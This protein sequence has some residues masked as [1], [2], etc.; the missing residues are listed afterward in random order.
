M[1]SFRLALEALWAHKRRSWLSSLGMAVGVASI[2]VLVSLAKGVQRDVVRQVEEL[3]VNLIILL[4][5]RLSPQNPFNP[6]SFIGLSTLQE[7]DVEV[8]RELPGV[9]RAAPIMFVAGGANRGSRWADAALILG[10]TP[11]WFQMRP[12]ALKTGRLLDE[13]DSEARVCVLGPLPAEQIFGNQ[14]PLGQYVT[15][16]RH[17]FQVVGVTAE[18][19]QQSL[20]G[21]GGF[22]YAI[23]VPV[24]AMQKATGSKQIHRVIVQT[25][26]DVDPES[27]VSRIKSAVRANHAGS[28]D[29]SVITQQDLLKR[30]FDLLNVLAVALTGITS[31][32]LFVG[33]IGVMNVM[34]MSVNE[35]VREI[36]IR[37]TVG[38]RRGDIFSQFLMEALLIALTG[39]FIGIALAVAVCV[40]L[41]ARTV[42]NPYVSLDTILLALGVCSLVGFVFGTFPAYRAAT[43]DPV[44]CLRYE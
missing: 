26:P 12:V 8:I 29:F 38:A 31:I 19:T 33:G 36:G 39:G 17:R 7:S 13:K 34:L 20:F 24:K 41:D 43:R 40:I 14:S 35:R 30:L 3:G 42:L 4:P 37:K 15:L 22:E 27:M 28:D 2:V 5:G 44:E 23:Y 6:M 10:T 1:K 32:A 21:S 11:E 16:N 18:Q 25:A 9:R